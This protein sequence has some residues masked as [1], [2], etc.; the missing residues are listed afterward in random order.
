MDLEP[1]EYRARARERW[2]GAAAGWE[3]RRAAMQASAAVVST[4]MVEHVEPQPGQTI[5]ELA[6][7]PGD[8]GLM[9]AELVG[10]S[11]RLISSDASEEMID[12]AL[13]TGMPVHVSPKF[14]AEHMG[15]PYHQASIRALE[16]PPKEAR[17]EGF[18]A[19]SGGSR[20]FLRYGYGDLHVRI[21]VEVPTH[22]SSAQRAKLEEYAQLCNGKESPLSQSFF[23]KAKKL[24]K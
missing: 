2:G 9:A 3:R 20:R 6:A 12:V 19:K 1:E 24:F 10:A 22:L 13:A 15:L 4:W 21:N 17:D 11:G 8:T 18:F 5:L 14:W 7:G 16:L 23:E